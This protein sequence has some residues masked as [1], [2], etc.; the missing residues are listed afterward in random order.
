MYQ[1]F[2][3]HE[4]ISWILTLLL[5]F[6]ECY[7]LPSLVLHACL[8]APT[9]TKSHLAPSQYFLTR[10]LSC[11]LC[12]THT[13]HNETYCESILSLHTLYS[14]LSV[15]RTHSYH[16][17]L[18]Y[19]WSRTQCIAAS[20]CARTVIRSSDSRD[21]HL[22]SNQCNQCKQTSGMTATCPRAYV[23]HLVSV[24]LDLSYPV[25]EPLQREAERTSVCG[26]HQSDFLFLSF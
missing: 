10:A 18:F 8:Q 12:R 13:V 22:R 5:W 14:L 1:C 23:T 20:T 19:D 11:V 6:P 26:K 7:N 21:I 9:H 3:Y 24:S 25:Q 16:A 2:H 4:R 17:Q 15:V